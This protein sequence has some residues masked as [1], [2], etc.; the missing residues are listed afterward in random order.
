MLQLAIIHA[1]TGKHCNGW[2]DR[3]IALQID[4]YNETAHEI[5]CMQILV[6]LTK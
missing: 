3:Q 1:G 6:K 5:T 4:E 2:S